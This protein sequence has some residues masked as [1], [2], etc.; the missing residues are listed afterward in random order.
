VLLA[1]WFLGYLFKPTGRLTS[2]LYLVIIG[3]LGMGVYAYMTL[4]TR[5]LDKLIGSRAARY[6][7]KLGL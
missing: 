5:Q 4:L 6:R 3:G 2:L 7:Q 1:N